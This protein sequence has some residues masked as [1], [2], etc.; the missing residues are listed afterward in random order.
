VGDVTDH[1]PIRISVS[2]SEKQ[3]HK[4]GYGKVNLEPYGVDPKGRHVYQKGER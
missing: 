3:E 4:E 1:A 2:T